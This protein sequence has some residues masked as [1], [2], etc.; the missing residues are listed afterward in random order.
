MKKKRKSGSDRKLQVWW[1]CVVLACLGVVITGAVVGL[2][3]AG[4]YAYDAGYEYFTRKEAPNSLGKG[5]RVAAYGQCKNAG[6]MPDQ[7][8]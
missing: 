5:G 7:Y 4:K 1:D 8:R 3:Y 2:L 6:W